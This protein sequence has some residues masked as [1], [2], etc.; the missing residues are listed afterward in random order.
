M[1]RTTQARVKRAYHR[2]DSIE[3]PFRDIA[4]AYKVLGDLSDAAIH[5][6][7]VVAGSD[8]QISPANKAVAVDFVM[9]EQRAARRFRH[10]DPFEAVGVGK[11]R[12]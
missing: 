5:C 2:F 6:Q 12:T 3:H 1:R 10:A 11:A 7:V 9:V 8:D 4:V